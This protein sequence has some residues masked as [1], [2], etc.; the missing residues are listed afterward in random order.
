MANPAG[1]QTGSYLDQIRQA[2]A[3]DKS[4]QA[5][6]LIAKVQKHAKSHALKREVAHLLVFVH[7]KQENYEEAETELRRFT[8]LFG[9]DAYL[10]GLFHFS[11]GDMKSALPFLMTAFDLVPDKQLGLMI[12]QSLF[13]NKDFTGIR[14]LCGHPVLSEVRWQLYVNL[15]TLAFTDGQFKVSAEAGQLAYEH[16]PDPNVAYNVACA[17][18]RYSDSREALEWL[19]RAF[20]S[21]FKAREALVSDPDL[22]ALRSL[23][24]FSSLVARFDERID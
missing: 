18:A 14:E 13:A 9:G 19:H 7:I 12:S 5:L 1:P 16:E 17:F 22:A 6:N 24:E 20:D 11:Q 23:S 3:E 15:Q 4:D 8:A 21:G 10:E 2:I